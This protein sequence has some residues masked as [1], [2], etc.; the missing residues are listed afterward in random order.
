[1]W[2][3]T[4]VPHELNLDS[5]MCRALTVSNADRDLSL[6][7]APQNQKRQRGCKGEN[8]WQ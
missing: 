8:R 1:M 5:I 3:R 4:Y 7:S 6:L 2:A